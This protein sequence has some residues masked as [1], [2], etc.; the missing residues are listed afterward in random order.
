VALPQSLVPR[1][2][3]HFSRRPGEFFKSKIDGSYPYAMSSINRL[4]G[5]ALSDGREQCREVARWRVD[6]AVR[7]RATV[8]PRQGGGS[9]MVSEW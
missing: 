4:P 7:P 1:V 6:E 9:A 2:D 3:L 5:S 8:L